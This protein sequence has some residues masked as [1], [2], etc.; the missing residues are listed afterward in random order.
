MQLEYYSSQI[1]TSQIKQIL[2]KYFDLKKVKV[3]Y[4]GSRVTGVS[5]KRSDIDIGLRSPE[6][7]SPKIKF[8]L[9]DDLDNLPILYKI[10][11]VDF[12]QTSSS[13]QNEALKKVE[14]IN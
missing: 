5:N 13:F 8:E 1:L 12:S 9:L 6:K 14:M 10:D 7:I 3:F 2:G 4:F 11:L